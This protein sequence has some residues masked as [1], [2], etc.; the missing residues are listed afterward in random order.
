MI[1]FIT[2]GLI[3]GSTLGEFVRNQELALGVQPHIGF[4]G[5]ESKLQSITVER[6]NELK[7]YENHK[8]GSNTRCKKRGDLKKDHQDR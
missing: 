2:I 3:P 4:D 1:Q 8:C 6:E 5:F 7:I